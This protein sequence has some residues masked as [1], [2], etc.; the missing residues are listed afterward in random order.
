[1][2]QNPA[3]PPYGFYNHSS[4]PPPAFVP[5]TSPEETYERERNAL[6]GKLNRMNST[7]FKPGEFQFSIPEA[8]DETRFLTGNT[9]VTINPVYWSQYKGG[10]YTFS[11]ERLDLG[12]ALDFPTLGAKI[13]LAD[14]TTLAALVPKINAA[15]G[16]HLEIGDYLDTPLPAMDVQSDY[17]YRVLVKADPRSYAFLGEFSLP[18]GPTAVQVSDENTVRRLYILTSDA[19]VIC[20]Q[21]NFAHGNQA[22]FE[23]FR[24]ATAVVVSDIANLYPSASGGV[25][26]NGLFTYHASV[27]LGGEATRTSTM[28][29]ADS[30]GYIVRESA[31]NFAFDNIP[32]HLLARNPMRD[33]VFGVESTAG[34][35]KYNARGVRDADWLPVGIAYIPVLIDLD[36]V[37]R[38]LC[39]SPV[40]TAPLPMPGGEVIQAQ[41]YL[42]DRLLPNGMLDPSFAPVTISGRGNLAPLPM[43]DI[44][45]VPESGGGFYSVFYGFSDNLPS[46]DSVNQVVVN[47]TALFDQPTDHVYPVN[48]VVK[49]KDNGLRDAD[50]NVLLKRYSVVALN[51]QSNLTQG[52]NVLVASKTGV[53][54]FTQRINSITQHPHRQPIVFTKKGELVHLNADQTNDSYRWSSAQHILAF[55]SGG[56]VSYGRA[57][58][59][60]G[61]GEWTAPKNVVCEYAPSSAPKRLVAQTGAVSPAMPPSILQVVVSEYVPATN[62]T[63]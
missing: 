25:I 41:Q 29:E 18:L 45:S 32:N 43:A 24:G 8:V 33:E 7:S 10:S 22:P 60:N 63:G 2:N 53:T 9:Q 52:D 37:G 15:F 44:A 38:I 57:Y 26:V 42:I 50:F 34:L 13:A 40:F 3:P 56:F 48:P 39:V 30:E 20:K 6:V 54:F 16:I 49:F 23:F 46:T 35:I 12:K 1:M 51:M 58:L 62:T 59:P 36:V 19:Q 4:S 28:V 11:Y 27:G 14:E 55:S 17:G 21:Q 31:V 5:S 61:P 47:A